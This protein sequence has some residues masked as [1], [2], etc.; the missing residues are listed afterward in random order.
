[1]DRSGFIDHR[2]GFNDHGVATGRNGLTPHRSFPDRNGVPDRGG[3]PDR[4]GGGAHPATARRPSPLPP[5]LRCFFDPR[6]RSLPR[7]T[8]L[9]LGSL[10]AALRLS[11]FPHLQATLWLL[12][13]L[14]AI[15][16]GIADTARCMR[17]RWDFY[18]GGVLLSVYMDLLVF[19]LVLFLLLYPALA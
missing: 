3:F 4:G 1:M 19:I 9:V 8:A 14:A 11:H 2:R 17:K 16:A 7:G 6:Q 12:L 13:P 15:G 5:A 10:A 18:H